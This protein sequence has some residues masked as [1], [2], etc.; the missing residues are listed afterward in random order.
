MTVEDKAQWQLGP[1]PEEKKKKK[2]KR[3]PP[4]ERKVLTV[5]FKKCRLIRIF[6]CLTPK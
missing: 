3:I 5:A 1:N 2:K 6:S 4:L